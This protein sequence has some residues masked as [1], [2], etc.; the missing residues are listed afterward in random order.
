[1]TAGALE[2]GIALLNKLSF[3]VVLGGDGL[4]D[5]PIVAQSGKGVLFDLLAFGAGGELGAG[6]G[7][8]CGGNVGFLP[9]VDASG[10]EIL[11]TGTIYKIV[12]VVDGI[13]FFDNDVFISIGDRYCIAGFQGYLVGA[14]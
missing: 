13:P 12:N 11:G 7:T 14:V 4:L 3:L 8:G 10:G 1:M 6:N 5:L 2:D 9:V